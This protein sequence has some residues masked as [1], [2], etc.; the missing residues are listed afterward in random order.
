MPSLAK[1]SRSALTHAIRRA[2]SS[3]PSAERAMRIASEATAAC[4]GESA[5]ENMCGLP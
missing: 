5:F 3:S 2:R 1:P 4:T